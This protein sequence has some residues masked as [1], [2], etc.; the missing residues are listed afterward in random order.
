MFGF[1]YQ[2]TADLEALQTF[3][4]NFYIHLS[5]LANNPAI[6]TGQRFYDD[7]LQEYKAKQEMK[8]VLA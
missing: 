1:M 7:L 6:L 2:Q 8:L 5:M 3:G 4:N